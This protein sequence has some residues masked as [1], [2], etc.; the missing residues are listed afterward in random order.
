MTPVDGTGPFE[1]VDATFPGVG[2]SW[3]TS[4][5][6]RRRVTARLRGVDSSGAPVISPAA[7]AAVLAAK[8]VCA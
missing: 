1:V 2:R 6:R 4:S 5:T 8:W 7:C 3:W